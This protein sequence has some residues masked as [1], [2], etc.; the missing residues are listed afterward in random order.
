MVIDEEGKPAGKERNSLATDYLHYWRPE[1]KNDYI[2][3]TALMVKLIPDDIAAY[4]QKSHLKNVVI[5]QIR[6]VLNY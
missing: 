3:G 4:D 6:A 2:A 1:R 5:P